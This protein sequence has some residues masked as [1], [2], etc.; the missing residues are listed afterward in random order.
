MRKI[1]MSKPG[2]FEFQIRMD[3]LR[4][5]AVKMVAETMRNSSERQ[6]EEKKVIVSNDFLQPLKKVNR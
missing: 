1:L 6:T 2:E 3:F 5:A 4:G